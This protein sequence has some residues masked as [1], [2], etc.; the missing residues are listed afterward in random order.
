MIT[1]EDLLGNTRE[2]KLVRL[3]QDIWD[4]DK[5]RGLAI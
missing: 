2:E 3:V 1:G 4:S 5:F